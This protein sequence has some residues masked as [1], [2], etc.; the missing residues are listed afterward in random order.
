MNPTLRLRKKA[1]QHAY[2]AAIKKKM[3]G[4]G[5]GLSACAACV[6]A[7]RVRKLQA[8]SRVFLSV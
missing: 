3:V 6:L 8:V 1:L 4:P 7:S 5:A 2:D